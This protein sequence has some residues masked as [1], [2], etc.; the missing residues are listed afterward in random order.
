MSIEPL[1]EAARALPD[2]LFIRGFAELLDRAVEIQRRTNQEA[3]WYDIPRSIGDDAALLTSEVSEFFEEFRF[4]GDT[5]MATYIDRETFKPCGGMIELADVFIRTL[6]TAGRRGAGEFERVHDNP[7]GVA[8][9]QTLG[10]AFHAK[11]HHNATRGKRH[12]GKHV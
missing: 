4:H 1:L 11:Y 12:G 2:E 7:R 10:Q 6:D 5:F 3:G 8:K 9:Y